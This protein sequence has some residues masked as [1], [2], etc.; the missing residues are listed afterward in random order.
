M[1]A[2]VIIDITNEALDHAYTY[3]VPEGLHL[4]A[5]DKVKV[6]FGTARA[7]GAAIFCSSRSRRI[8]RR[9]GSKT[10]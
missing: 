3:R 1:Y 9:S 7:P 2:R 10:F 6:P 5:G 4:Q 8:M